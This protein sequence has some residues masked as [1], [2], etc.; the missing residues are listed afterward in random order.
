MTLDGKVAA[1]HGRRTEIS[2]PLGQEV[3]QRLRDQHDAVLVG[4]GTVIADDPRLTCRIEGGRNPRR[5]VLDSTLRTPDGAALLS[6]E[7]SPGTLFICT[8]AATPARIGH[9]RALGASVRVYPGPRPALAAVLRDLGAEG[10]LS[11][12]VEGGPTVHAGFLEARLAQRLVVT[13]APSL[14]GGAQAP[15][16]VAGSGLAALPVPVT[17]VS[18]QV[19]GGEIVLRATIGSRRAEAAAGSEDV[20]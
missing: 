16:P 7:L 2:G 4:V 9:L 6:Q 14:L 3:A 12:L 15:G 17:S 19:H 13:L 10:V 20:R 11:L 5:I 1:S 18:T 8:D